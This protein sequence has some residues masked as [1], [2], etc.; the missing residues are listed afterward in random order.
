LRPDL[1][2]RPVTEA[3]VKEIAKRV[4][5]VCKNPYAKAYAQAIFDY[6]MTG[7]ELEVQVLYVL[8]NLSTWRGEEARRCKEE[9]RRF[10]H[11]KK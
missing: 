2:K 7:H 1:H 8:S 4:L 5:A 9:L 3:R 6:S 10:A 11:V